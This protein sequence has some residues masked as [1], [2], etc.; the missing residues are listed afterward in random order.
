M[1]IEAV[2]FF[3]LRMPEVLDIGDGSQDAVL[4]RVSAGGQVGW[5]QCEASPLTTIA[6]WACPMSHSACK[7][8]SASVL[9]QSLESTADIVRIGDDVRNASLDL[10]QAEHALSG[11]DIA[12]WDLLG[13]RLDE[14]VHRLLGYQ[15]AHPKRPYASVLFGDV[16]EETLDKARSLRAAGFTAGKFGWGPYGKGSAADDRDQMMAAREGLGPEGI[17]LIDAGTAWGEDVE[18]AGERIAAWRDARVTWIEEPFRTG[19]LHAY[20]ALA[21]RCAPV[22][23]AGGEG[24]HN[25]Y[26]ARHLIDHGGIGFIQIDTGRIGGI[27]PAKAVADYAVGKG[28]AF[29]NHT[30][31][32][33]LSLC[34]SLQP[35]VGQ[36]ANELCEYPT[37]A[38]PLSARLTRER[39][40]PDK[41]GMIRIPEAPGLGIAPDEDVITEYLVDVEIRVDNRTLY[42]TPTVSVR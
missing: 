17:L 42:S 1:R 25:V 30:F 37:E 6:A 2:D 9:G 21:G 27:T 8:V 16:P 33:H 13:K 19:A 7:P 39:L 35:Y 4:V 40:V 36:R 12:L 38:K 23:V 18:R 20:A 3:Y 10:L 26:M 28:I 41:D 29:V 14:P 11:I 22:C 24:S 5:G 34:A 31:T 15:W 32:S